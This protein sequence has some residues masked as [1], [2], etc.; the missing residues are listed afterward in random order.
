M[1]KHYL[2]RIDGE[3]LFE[4]DCMISLVRDY[5]ERRWNNHSFSIKVR[6]HK[7]TAKRNSYIK[8]KEAITR[9]LHKSFLLSTYINTIFQLSHL[10]LWSLSP[11]IASQGTIFLIL[12]HPRITSFFR[13]I[14]CVPNDVIFSATL[15]PPASPNEIAPGAMA[16]LSIGC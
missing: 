14:I 15:F 13:V 5:D 7:I 6:G 10:D 11:C 16:R 12:P 4:K 1:K 8:L 9:I 2:Q 3:R